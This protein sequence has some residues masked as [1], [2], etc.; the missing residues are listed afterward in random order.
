MLAIVLMLIFLCYR[1]K[2]MNKYIDISLIGVSPQN[3]SNK[4]REEQ[5]E[6]SCSTRLKLK[7]YEYIYFPASCLLGTKSNTSK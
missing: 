3:K 7:E 5:K 4:N 2:Q 6:G 1:I